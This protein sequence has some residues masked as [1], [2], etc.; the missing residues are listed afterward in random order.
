M[1]EEKKNESSIEELNKCYQYPTR[2][3]PAPSHVPKP[4][5]A[6]LPQIQ[7]PSETLLAFNESD[8]K[9]FNKIRAKYGS[10]LD[11]FYPDDITRFVQGYSHEKEREVET[12]KRID[13]LLKRGFEPE[14]HKDEWDFR[15]I[16]DEA[17][18]NNEE[19]DSLKTWPVFMYGY[20]KYGHPVMYD[21]IGNS[22]PAD[23]DACFDGKIRKLKTFRFR[24]LRR[25]HNAKRIQTMRYGYDGSVNDKGGLNAITKHCIVMDMKNFYA[26]SLTAKYRR[27]VQEI[28]GDES[29]L[30]PNTLE[31]MYIVNA[32]W[33]FRFAWKI[34]SNFVHPITVKKINILGSDY[35]STMT[36]N[37]AKD[38]I[39]ASYGG[40]GKLPIKLGYVADVDNDIID[41]DYCTVPDPLDLS[42]VPC[43]KNKTKNDSASDES[44]TKQD[45]QESKDDENEEN[46]PNEQKKA[47]NSASD[48]SFV[49]VNK[50]DAANAT[51]DDSKGDG[52]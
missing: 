23:L 41:G 48:D 36:Q 33:P 37:I 10:R 45:E 7:V 12:F 47:A 20:D 9:M 43:N 21:E 42:T 28:I 50:E 13:A 27:L 11:V 1:A 49:K 4:I 24:V 26:K 51:A 29:N 34:I 30:W 22:N 15:H 40:D 35:L 38:Q 31:T 2:R 46:K 17:M 44:K 5:N 16:L 6:E 25:L 8:W 32:P 3:N 19:E 52:N 18:P 39:P 14:T